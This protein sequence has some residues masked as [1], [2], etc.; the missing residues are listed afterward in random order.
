MTSVNDPTGERRTAQN[1]QRSA[2]SAVPS[3]VAL[4]QQLF[5]HAKQRARHIE[6]PPPLLSFLHGKSQWHAM[7]FQDWTAEVRLACAV[8]LVC[9]NAFRSKTLDQ[10]AELIDDQEA[11]RAVST[12]T[13]V[14]TF[15]G[16]FVPLARLAFGHHAREAMIMRRADARDNRTAL[17]TA[18]RSLQGGHS[19]LLAPDGP[20]GTT[21][22]SLDVLGAKARMAQSAAFLAYSANC[23]TA[24]YTVVRRKARFVV[25]LEPG[26]ARQSGEEL[27]AFNSRLQQFYAR[28]VEGIF[29]GDPKNITIRP[30]WQRTFMNYLAA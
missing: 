10:Y 13:L 20:Y 18:L 17:F 15:H 23:P 11:L 14:L 21:L 29:S 12:K 4:A 1:E 3:Q 22:E 6:I 2:T 25:H 9:K 7:S 5:G 27:A 26:P 8:D 19:V 28:Q 30:H 16:S 24:W